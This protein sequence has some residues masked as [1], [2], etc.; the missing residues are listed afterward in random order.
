MV[1]ELKLAIKVD[2]DAIEQS[3]L[4]QFANA[5]K[6]ANK[7]VL[8]FNNIDLDDKA[9][10]AKFKEM[11]K[12]AGKNPIDLSIDKSSIE[13]L[14]AIS[15][16]LGNIFDIAKGKSL[17]D[18][19]ATVSDVNRIKN[20]ELDL[21]HMT[22]KRK[23]SY[24]EIIKKMQTVIQLQEKVKSLDSKKSSD[25][26]YYDELFDEY[27]NWSDKDATLTGITDRL[28]EIYSKFNGK[29]TLI[30]ED[31]IKEVSYLFDML[32][33]AGETLTNLT[34]KEKTFFNN[35]RFSNEQLFNFTNND[36]LIEE[37]IEK[38]QKELQSLY[39]W[40]SKF[41]GVSFNDSIK[42]EINRLTREMQLGEKEVSQYA[43]QLLKIFN[44]KLSND[45]N[46]TPIKEEINSTNELKEIVNKTTITFEDLKTIISNLPSD[47]ISQLNKMFDRT[48]ELTSD[49][50]TR[51]EVMT[52]E[53]GKYFSIIGTRSSASFFLNNEGEFT[54][55]PNK[56]K[57]DFVI[58]KNYTKGMKY[59]SYDIA[60]IVRALKEQE[61]Q[62]IAT[63]QAEQKLADAG[64]DMD[65]SS[66]SESQNKIQEELKETQKQAEQTSEALSK[67]DDVDKSNISSDN[68]T[69]QIVENEKKKQEAYKAT[70]D[71]VMYH[72]GVISKLNKAETNGRFYGSDRGTG[73]FGT[74][75]YFV[76]SAT[77]HELDNN[78]S[79]SKLPYTSIDISQYDNL[80]K[81]TTN[82]IADG[83]H[84]FLK[85]LTKF[86]QGSDS[87]SVSELFSQFQKVFGETVMDMQEFD[88]KLEQ[89]KTY[90]QN[91]NMS[92]RGDSVSTQFMKSLGY[93]GVDTRGTKY[94]DTRYGTVIYDLKEESI[95]QANITDE[96]QKQGQMLEKI[97]YEKG[98][99][100]DKSED[101][102]IQGILDQQAK[103]KEI[104]AEFN[105]LY[106]ST[107]LKAYES[108][109]DSVNN[110]LK[111]NDNI[112]SECSSAIANADEG[113]KQFAKEMKALGLEMS[114]EEIANTANQNRE[115]YQT[116][117]DE[118]EK[119]RPLLEAR[120]HELE[121]NLQTEYELAN[122]AR[123][124]AKAI[125]EERNSPIE[126]VFQGDTTSAE[127]LEEE[128]KNIDSA[129]EKA[130]ESAK[131][132]RKILSQVGEFD[133]DSKV[134]AMYKRNDGQLESWTWRAKKDDEGNVLYDQNGKI[135][136]DE[137]TVTVISKYEQL[138]KIIVKADNE[139]RNLQKD[140]AEIK[141]YDPTA[142]TTNI[143]AKIS[144]QKEYIR[145]L[146]QTVKVI[147]QS[148]E[149]LLDEQQIIEARNKAAREYALT[150][151][152]KQ[153][154]T[155]AKQS[156]SDEK[157][158]L[159][160]IE[161]VNRALNK[162]QITID[163]IEKTYNKTTNPDLDREVSNQQDLAELAQ[164]K[165]A[166]Q[167]KINLLQGQERNSANEKEFLELEKLIAEY[168]EL[169]KYKLKAN[170]PSKQE[171]GG[172][173]LQTLIQVQISNYDKLI[174]KAEKYG[175]A[176]SDTVE[177]LK[178]QRDIL[179]K[180]DSD[181]KYSATAD[182]YY[183]SRD[184]Y[185]V[186]SAALSAFEA[187]TKVIQDYIDAG[188][189]FKSQ[190]D[191][192]S[193]KPDD[194]HQ[195][196]SWTND[197]NELNAKIDEYNSKVKYLKEN[198]I[199][200][201]EQVKEVKNL[202]DKIEETI[203]V[204]TKTPQTKRGWTDIGA[205][206]AAEKVA[207]V[208][209]QNTKMSKEARDAIRAYYNE[210]R[211]GNPSQPIDEI[212]VKVNQL[213]QKERELG[214]VGKSF[215]E[216]FKEKV[217][218]GGAAQ[219]AGMVGFYDVINV[220]R[221]I[222]TNIKEVD[223]ALTELR[224]V[225]DATEQ[226]LTANFKNSADTAKEL[227][228]TISDV[229]SATADWSRMGYNIDQ[230]EE[231]ARVSTLYKN[232]GD[233]IDIETANN[234]L[235]ST[236]QGFQ[237]DASQAESIIDKFNEVAKFWRNRMV[238]YG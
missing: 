235:I 76:D 81:A 44:I 9:I 177:K 116:R 119:E 46:V 42:L 214:R 137:P 58:D 206:K 86:T 120:K 85:N 131:E 37:E 238:T 155:D 64:K 93:G 92:D 89:L 127:K 135:D 101:T 63:A 108:E 24:D 223:T 168:K 229:I 118:L 1:E 228:A 213:V 75:H 29:I 220:G 158:R 5:E 191:N 193:I 192:L 53:L 97:N 114:Q 109:L 90:M 219:L 61:K 25:G 212:L 103:S 14:S 203:N 180:M 56:N 207:N 162:Q 55:K 216:I 62:A 204:M 230:A 40:F 84:T 110:K 130:S 115:S 178:E 67:I 139:L 174:T 149:Y 78:S 176:T 144:D 60:D 132:Y 74:G 45:T 88:A 26:K 209:K 167:T 173:N 150:T 73:Y 50:G 6:M 225:S 224:K 125:V 12:M 159:A 136:Y 138:E 33:G 19:S 152:A 66:I 164:K 23:V 10:E 141:S 102:R 98:Q 36:N 202:R 111:E 124:R 218:Y 183:A 189:K 57:T 133:I 105:K 39:S 170:N 121:Q 201:G 7:V 16:Q 59:D 148:D 234:S 179:S 83:L 194:Q 196:S 197:L 80:F 165:L 117:I 18:S 113:A 231:L 41:E 43:E 72:A 35:K 134:S 17:I 32:K 195:F 154:K 49:T 65:N 21:Y 166:I 215:R 95:L 79:Y 169:A 68:I 112:I 182:Q 227:G 47:K 198:N 15:K 153:E 129:T 172:Q 186:E 69:N 233:G 99:V 11:Q 100:F 157:K 38:T 161:Q 200:D 205:S 156:A 4:K 54:R 143:E 217:I 160:N 91:S 237:L 210:L 184:T 221:E 28:K 77:K 94:A 185:K 13:M 145:L 70:A 107:Q 82:E 71:A 188:T 123:E 236:L 142:S 208:L 128:I 2:D 87:F 106:D 163:A 226:R 151:G 211:S 187:E 20:A 31:H 52:S 190:F 96:L 140:L 222:V 199:V 171:L 8:T 51:L 22:E 147:S 30:D 104:D 34:S 181:G 3:L 126:D 146:E 232:V 48:L 175:D 27:V 122:A